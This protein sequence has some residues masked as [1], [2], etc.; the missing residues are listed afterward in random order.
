AA[1]YRVELAP[2]VVAT[3]VPR[4]SLRSFCEHQLRWARSTRD[5]RRS[6]YIGLGLTYM[7]PWALASLIASGGAL[8]SISLLSMALMVR[9][10]LALTVGVG[11]LRDGQVLRDLLLLPLRDFFGLFFWAWSYASDEV[12]WRGERFT[13]RNGEMKQLTQK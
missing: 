2:V 1:G 5:S 10:A 3:A 13:L 12:V 11:I 4:Y 7:L 6:G 8:W 9:V